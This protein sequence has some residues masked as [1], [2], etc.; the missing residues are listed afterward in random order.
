MAFNA[1]VP[2]LRAIFKVIC[3]ACPA[4]PNLLADHLRSQDLYDFD[5]GYYGALFTPAESTSARRRQDQFIETLLS[6]FD[7]DTQSALR[8]AI[9]AFRRSANAQSNDSAS[10]ARDY[11]ASNSQEELKRSFSGSNKRQRLGADSVYTPSRRASSSINPSSGSSDR[12]TPLVCCMILC[13]QYDSFYS[14]QPLNIYLPSTRYSSLS[15][16]P[17]V[18]IMDR[19]LASWLTR[20]IRSGWKC[21]R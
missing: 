7:A 5:S 17:Q 9:L 2:L 6:F 20:I 16:P 15:F 8:G 14:V 11:R 4:Y 21:C 10:G 18:G 1:H 13:R 12:A 3:D 19:S